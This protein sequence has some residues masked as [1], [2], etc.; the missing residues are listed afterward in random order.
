M[1]VWL[2]SC[3][4]PAWDRDTLSVS[5]FP[6]LT[7]IQGSLRLSIVLEYNRNQREM[8]F[9][10]GKDKECC[11]VVVSVE[12]WGGETKPD[13]MTSQRQ[14]GSCKNLEETCFLTKASWLWMFWRGAG[15]WED[16]ALL[17][18]VFSETFFFLPNW[19]LKDSFF[20]QGNVLTVTT[21]AQNSLLF[22]CSLLNL[23][24]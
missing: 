8:Q 4:C 14:A 20:Y 18:K 17:E 7:G 1:P 24:K 16:S 13:N 23:L 5:S 21:L 6:W 19:W 22:K 12:S 2:P 15:G 9:N 11:C 10:S 3:K